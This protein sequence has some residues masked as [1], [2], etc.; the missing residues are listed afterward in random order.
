METVQKEKIYGYLFKIILSLIL[1]F[2][3]YNVVSIV[4]LS[5]YRGKKILTRISGSVN[6]IESSIRRAGPEKIEAEEYKSH[7]KEIVNGS[8]FAKQIK[9]PLIF[10]GPVRTRVE[11]AGEEEMEYKEVKIPTNTEIIFKGVADNLAYINL[12]RELEGQWYEHGFPTKTGER[13]GGKKVIG[14]ETLD[15]TT[16]YILQDIVR[17]VQKPITLMKKVVILDEAGEFVGTKMVAGETFMKTTSKIKYK[18]GYGRTK[19]LW[20]GESEKIAQLEGKELVE[21]DN[22]YEKTIDT[23]ESTY[24][25]VVDKVKSVVTS[26][27]KEIGETTKQEKNIDEVK[28]SFEKN[29][30]TLEPIMQEAG[31]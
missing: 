24:G 11:N 23:I 17:N 13:I 6:A 5:H 15:F 2:C 25:N 4:F 30:E 28:K 10:S 8:L 12:R 19:E 31:K 27:Y 9:K 26:E 3:L 29:I 16:N 18:D 14:G 20:L 1:V 7:L 22:W 21:N